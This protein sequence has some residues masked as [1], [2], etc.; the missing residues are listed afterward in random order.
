[1][2]VVL[3]SSMKM[4]MSVFFH[5]YVGKKHVTQLKF[6]TVCNPFLVGFLDRTNKTKMK[7][8]M[9]TNEVISARH[10]QMWRTPRKAPV[11]M[12]T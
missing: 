7:M 1:M 11:T 9:T 12:M 10:H 5:L 2:V 4:R 6:E 3:A 8:N